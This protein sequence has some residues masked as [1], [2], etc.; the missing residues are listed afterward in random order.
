MAAE[1]DVS[2]SVRTF[3]ELTS[4][5]SLDDGLIL[6]KMRP[7]YNVIGMHPNKTLDWQRSYFFVKCD[8]STFEDP[9]DGV[10]HVLWNP[11]LG[12]TSSLARIISFLPSDFSR[13]SGRLS[14][15]RSCRCEICSIE[16]GEY[17]LGEGSPFDR[18]NFQE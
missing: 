8:D 18:R 5:S 7:S 12:R 13:L 1:I 3:E 17:F 10:C 2:L 4:I 14:Y 6:I 11:L 15:E 9:P 16:L